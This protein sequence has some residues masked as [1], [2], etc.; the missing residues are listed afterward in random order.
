MKT[1]MRRILTTTLALAVMAGGTAVAQEVS[2]REKQRQQER[3][4]EA[5]RRL[6]E[7]QHALQEALTMLQEEQSAEAQQRMQEASNQLRQ[8]MSELNR[9]R[10][11]RAYELFADGVGPLAIAIGGSGARM[12]V[13]LSTG[14]E[15]A[16]TDSIGALLDRV[17]DEGPAGQAGLE[18]GDIITMANGK[19]L[20]RT[21][22]RDTSPS[23]KLTG[24]RDEFE[25]GDTLRVEYR[26]GSETRTA[27]I[28]L[29]ELESDVNW[30]TS[31]AGPDVLVS[32]GAV[33]GVRA[34]PFV[35][36][37]TPRGV[38]TFVSGSLWPMSW[39]EMELVELDEDLGA[40][41]GTSEGLLVV[42]APE[43]SDL[44]F[45]SGDVILDVDGRRL[46]DQ[47]HLIR[48]MRSYEA[49]ETMN[50]GI[51]RN[52]THEMVS[53]AVPERDNDFS[54]NRRR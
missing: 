17:V 16:A 39:F 26:R 47:S 51:M 33:G 42:R 40:Y 6:Q 30:V 52:R 32:P 44:D 46:T 1:N 10:Y 41:F 37:R 22:R 50:I 19:P 13:Y 18:A 9:N 23:N 43:D 14:R 54:W 38:S 36:M 35:S 4:A 5:E 24:I 49:G 2:E 48:I 12:G 27:D 3:V 53:V 15:A 45:R 25:I 34:A 7:A 29:D 20:A 28:V 31:Y 21:S 8:A 11:S